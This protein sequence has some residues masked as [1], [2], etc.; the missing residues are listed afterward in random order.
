MPNYAKGL[1]YDKEHADTYEKIV[2]AKPII[3][4]KQKMNEKHT[5]ALAEALKKAKIKA[6][7][8]TNFEE[9]L[10]KVVDAIVEYKK[11]AGLPIG[12]IKEHKHHYVG[13]AREFLRA[14]ERENK[15]DVLEKMK[16]GELDD[17]ISTYAMGQ[18]QNDQTLFV[19]N[20]IHKLLPEK[21]FDFY[22]GIASY[23][24]S[25]NPSKKFSKGKLAQLANRDVLVD[26]LASSIV[27]EQSN[28]L[29]DIKKKEEPK[30]K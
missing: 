16:L 1:K 4:Y 14:Y 10:E 23:H 7:S 15:I 29:Q 18:K 2:N 9:G 8:I 20:H 19:K 27:N 6:G 3:D 5:D 28:V 30:K 13:E 22:H 26:Y 12:D 21:G 17:I 25:L 24:A 11:K